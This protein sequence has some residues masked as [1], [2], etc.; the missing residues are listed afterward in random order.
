MQNTLL[1]SP[2]MRRIV[3]LSANVNNLAGDRQTKQVSQTLFNDFV[4]KCQYSMDESGKCSG[5]HPNL[6]SAVYCYGLRQSLEINDYNA[7]NNLYT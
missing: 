4:K 2:K 3:Q 5:I 7:V 6:R 1:Q